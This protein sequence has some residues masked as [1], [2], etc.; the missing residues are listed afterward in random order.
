MEK[1]FIEP[2]KSTPLVD[3]DPQTR[4]LLI[5]GESYPEYAAKFY[6]PVFTWLT[7]FLEPEDS[8]KTVTIDLEISYFNSSSSKALM[9]IF[10]ILEEAAE[11]GIEIV[12]NWRFDKENEAAKECGEEFMEDIESIKFNMVEL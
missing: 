6:S 1:L 12:V 11:R 7:T 3:F 9:N 8:E 4:N 2:T 5:K 10:D